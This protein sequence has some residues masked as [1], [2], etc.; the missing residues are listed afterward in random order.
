MTSMVW[1]ATRVLLFGI[2]LTKM[3]VLAIAAILFQSFKILGE[4]GYYSAVQCY[5]CYRYR[6]M[7]QIN[8]LNP[9]RILFVHIFDRVRI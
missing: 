6:L 9:N 1:K 5:T 3:A 7:P 4:R 8:V 2:S